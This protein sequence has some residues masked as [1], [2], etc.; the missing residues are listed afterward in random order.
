MKVIL[1]AS[2]LAATLMGASFA[3]AQSDNLINN[4]VDSAA[5]SGV[6]V[7][8]VLN[9]PT[10]NTNNVCQRLQ[11]PASKCHMPAHPQCGTCVRADDRPGYKDPLL[12]CVAC[13]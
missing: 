4:T 2:L 7:E 8:A 6:N 3:S 5:S 1:C 13:P 10:T 9:D 11:L 12:G